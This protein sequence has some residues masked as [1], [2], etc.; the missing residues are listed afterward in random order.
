VT[1]PT[2]PVQ[3]LTATEHGAA[4]SHPRTEILALTG[5]RGLAVLWIVLY[6]LRLPPSAPAPLRRL[7]DA[8]YLGVP[9]F[10]ML[11]GFVLAYNYPHL[12]PRSGLRPLGRFFVARFARIVPLS[13]IISCYLLVMQSA[14]G[15]DGWMRRVFA[16]QAWA[17]A[18]I[19]CLYVAFPV[20]VLMIRSLVDRHGARGL[21]TAIGVSFGAQLVVVLAVY[22]AGGFEQGAQQVHSFF[23]RDPL[24]WVPTFALGITIAFAVSRGFALRV[25]TANLI[26]AVCL[27]AIVAVGVQRL[28]LSAGRFVQYGALWSVPLGLLL[29]TLAV[30]RQSVLARFLSTRVMVHLGVLALPLF[31]LH[32]ELLNGFGQK[33][34]HGD[35]LPAYLM[36]VAITGILLMLSEGAHRYLEA[37][38]RGG[39][40]AI[41]RRL[42][43]RT[44]ESHEDR[45]PVSR[46]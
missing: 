33:L 23:Y 41:A 26:Q 5:L 15:V 19:A 4:L 35:G 12:D 8:G 2:P 29:L 34:A 30:S 40:M 1:A 27:L 31:L 6:H 22:L 36:V 42:D 20:V 43:R 16:D 37:P 32:R 13:V 39:I 9:L 17:F 7:I 46:S 38:A 25:R 11:S 3:G 18:L 44:T 28:G 45:V 24:M 14:S 21:L 10:V